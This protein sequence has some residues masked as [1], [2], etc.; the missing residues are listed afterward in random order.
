MS[1]EPLILKPLEDHK[2]TIIFLHGLGDSGYGWK[3][4]FEIVQQHIK[5][6]KVILPHAYEY[7]EL[8]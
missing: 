1:Q 8:F 2:A 4:V 7:N 6:A 5:C 3:D